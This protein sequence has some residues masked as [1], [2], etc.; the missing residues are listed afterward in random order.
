MVVSAGLCCFV[1][2]LGDGPF[3]CLFQVLEATAPLDWWS[4]LHSQTPQL[5]T[6]PQA[7]HLWP[8]LCPLSS[9]FKNAEEPGGLLST[10]L[11]RVRHD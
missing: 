5:W 6:R 9:T 2:P 8:S 4:L 1:R 10:A 7:V 3:T 11:Q